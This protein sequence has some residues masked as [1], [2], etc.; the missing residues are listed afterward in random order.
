MLFFRLRAFAFGFMV[1]NDVIALVVS[2]RTA[3]CWRR[4][5]AAPL[6]RTVAAA[7]FAALSHM[8]INGFFIVSALFVADVAG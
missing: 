6:P 7:R 5:A 4:T 8:L 3:V 1:Q 2:F